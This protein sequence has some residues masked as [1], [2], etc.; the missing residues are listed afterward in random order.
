MPNKTLE[1]RNQKHKQELEEKTTV[2]QKKFK[3][4]VESHFTSQ[5]CDIFDI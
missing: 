4:D 1:R 2:L 5:Q 3:V